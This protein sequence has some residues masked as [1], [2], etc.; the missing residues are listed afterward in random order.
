[1]RT[2]KPDR[3]LPGQAFLLE[4]APS[5][6]MQTTRKRTSIDWKFC[7]RKL[8][9]YTPPILFI[10]LMCV[11]QL[12]VY[13]EGKT[14][15]I[16]NTEPIGKNFSQLVDQATFPESLPLWNGQSSPKFE[17]IEEQ[18]EYRNRPRMD[19]WVTQVRE[20]TLTFY[21][22]PPENSC[23]TGVVI[24]PGGGYRGL[25]LDKEGHDVARWMN[26]LGVTAVVLK[27]RLRDYGQPAPKDDVQRAIAEVRAR[28][29]QLDIDSDRIGVVGFS[30][31]GHL[32]STAATQFRHFRLNGVS[33][34]SRPDFAVLVYPVITMDQDH[35]HAG[36][37]W[38][39]LGDTPS[40]ELV[41][42]YSNHLHVS[43]RTPPTFL[44]H[45]ED[46]KAVPARNSQLFFE[47]LQ[48]HDVP[49]RLVVYERG[50]HGF[51]LVSYKSPAAAWPRQCAQWLEDQGWLSHQ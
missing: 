17:S 24:C 40:A 33:V 19:R 11:S 22:A 5:G 9:A 2:I 7:L 1:M 48:D 14:A 43:S 32:A 29:K 27:Y 10:G 3:G 39:L 45:A 41:A 50:G 18:V 13:A 12:S 42:E 25:A 36:S 16:S 28:S 6:K 31:G 23:R 26:S 15:A 34:S 47:A 30:A 46:D 8:L 37:R 49:A 51:G 21:P 44:V 35:G 38:N 20:P 4:F